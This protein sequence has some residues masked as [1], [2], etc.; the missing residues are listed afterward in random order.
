LP[1]SLLFFSVFGRVAIS[2]DERINSPHN[3][4]RNCLEFM[5]ATS[6]NAEPQTGQGFG[7]SL[8]SYV[9][10]ADISR[11]RRLPAELRS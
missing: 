9:H 3:G 6:S 8:F 4:Q 5:F 2:V 10:N 11:G 7:M 1:P